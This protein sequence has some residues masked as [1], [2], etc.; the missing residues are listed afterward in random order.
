MNKRLKWR[1]IVI[2]IMVILYSTILWIIP[3][4]L[5]NNT[6]DFLIIVGVLHLCFSGIIGL[7]WVLEKSL[8]EGFRL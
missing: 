8:N 1:I 6:K 2:A 3:L 5:T 4:V 7:F